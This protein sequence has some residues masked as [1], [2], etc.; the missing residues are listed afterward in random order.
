MSSILSKYYQ[1]KRI[2]FFD[3]LYPQL[4]N[5]QIYQSIQSNFR[6]LSEENSQQEEKYSNINFTFLETKFFMRRLKNI[7]TQNEPISLKTNL[8][9]TQAKKIFSE[10]ILKNFK[11]LLKNQIIFKIHYNKF[12]YNM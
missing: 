1:N 3:K 9:E 5:Q 10:T 12:I 2:E 4:L 11:N 6:N 8:E 7:F